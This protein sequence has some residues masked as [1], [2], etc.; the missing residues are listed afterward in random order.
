MMGEGKEPGLAADEDSGA[1]VAFAVA[2]I[3]IVNL[4]LKRQT[5][6]TKGKTCTVGST[7]RI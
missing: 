5:L 6:E 2:P 1:V 4:V 7:Q 3:F